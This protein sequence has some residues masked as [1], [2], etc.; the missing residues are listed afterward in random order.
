MWL[1]SKEYFIVFAMWLQVFIVMFVSEMY[2]LCSGY[3]KPLHSTR[4]STVMTPQGAELTTQDL[5]YQLEE[6]SLI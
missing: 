3:D 4:I 5:L 1:I 6:V 2:E